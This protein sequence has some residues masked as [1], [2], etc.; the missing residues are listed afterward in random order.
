MYKILVA[1]F[2]SKV[3]FLD[4]DILYILPCLV[5]YPL[6]VRK[7][8]AHTGYPVRLVGI[9]AIAARFKFYFLTFIIADLF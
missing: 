4:K 1:A 9:Y 7:S 5:I 8:Y 3:I 6:K 2:S